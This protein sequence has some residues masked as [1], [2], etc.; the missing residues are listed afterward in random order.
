MIREFTT[1][2]NFLLR[3][4]TY[5]TA[6]SLL[7]LGA[8]YWAGCHQFRPSFWIWVLCLV[9][10]MVPSFVGVSLANA[11]A[12]GLALLYH[13]NEV[14]L[15]Y[16]ALI[17]FGVY[18]GMLNVSVVHNCA[19]RNFRPR[20]LNRVLGEICSLHL[21]SGFPGFAILHLLHHR[22]ADDP[23]L[24][25]HPNGHQTYW[26][27]LNGLKRSLG[28]AFR[29]FHDQQWGSD[30][31]SRRRWQAVRVLL[32]MNRV[33]RALLI[34]L[35]CGPLGFTFFY[36]PSILANQITYAH[37]NYYSH[38]H[39]ADGR[40]E[41]VDLNHTWGYRLLNFLLIGIYC[42]ATH[43]RHAYLLNPSRRYS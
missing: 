27:Y 20:W 9:P 14:S 31:G 3:Y 11:L 21:M 29:R 8:L 35:L 24:D 43:H 5:S 1:D 13:A 30:V 7:A 36:I 19:H 37:I 40:V 2:R 22:H 41:I 4:Y 39:H 12:A 32:S 26:Q 10:F 17:P 18:A 15:W 42:H 25:P 16:L 38:V 34:L 23:V 6:L 28:A 33:I